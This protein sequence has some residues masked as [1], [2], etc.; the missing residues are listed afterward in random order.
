MVAPHTC[1]TV[2]DTPNCDSGCRGSSQILVCEIRSNSKYQVG[3][4]VF[5]ALP[6]RCLLFPLKRV[7]VLN[8]KHWVYN[9][10]IAAVAQL[11]H[12]THSLT[13]ESLKVQPNRD[14][15]CKAS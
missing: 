4:H 15:K 6:N 7:K 14:K 2:Q 9:Q 5:A 8:R 1:F 11:Y 13:Y 3:L 10:I 12:C